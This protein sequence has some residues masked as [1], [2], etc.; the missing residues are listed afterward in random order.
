[1]TAVR[2]DA[3]NI[4]E[5]DNGH[6]RVIAS[7][8]EVA[9]DGFAIPVSAWDL[10]AHEANPV[11]LWAHD[12]S[13][14]DSVIGR[15]R[16]F[17]TETALEAEIEFAEPGLNPFADQVARM[18][19]AGYLRA[20]SVGAAI[21]RAERDG[22]SIRVL[23]AELLDLSV[24]PVGGDPTAVAVARALDISE[25]TLDRFF[26]NHNE[27]PTSAR[28]TAAGLR[29]RLLEVAGRNRP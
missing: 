10:A 25:P 26:I 29:L 23:D 15:A 20:V 18:W 11:L 21:H 24:V 14:L 7:S 4:T 12:R 27:D 1:L 5:A 17:K 2:R 28:I 22:D 13:S 9:R 19:R 8:P 16:V 6:Y 3:L